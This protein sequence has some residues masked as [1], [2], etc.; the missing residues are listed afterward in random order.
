MK[1]NL[2]KVRKE[3]KEKSG[4]NAKVTIAKKETGMKRASMKKDTRKNPRQ[5]VLL[6]SL[7]LTTCFRT[8]IIH[9]TIK[10][11]RK[12]FKSRTNFSRST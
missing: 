5:K 10:A 12:S 4:R 6:R 7:G 9:Y 8:V 3:R 11:A 1:R 2:K